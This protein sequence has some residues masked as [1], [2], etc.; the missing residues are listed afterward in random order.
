MWDIDIPPTLRS[1]SSIGNFT[2]RPS[3]IK[4]IDMN[5]LTALTVFYDEEGIMGIYGHHGDD[6]AITA[7][8]NLHETRQQQCTWRYFPLQPGERI[9]IVWVL[10]GN[11]SFNHPILA[12]PISRTPSTAHVL[13]F[14]R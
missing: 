2:N 12:V 8:E 11:S 13:N 7:Y 6:S 10:R 1:Y 14:C 5:G 3:R 9:V 4:T